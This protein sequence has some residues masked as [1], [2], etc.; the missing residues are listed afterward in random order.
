MSK[1]SSP[2]LLYIT[3]ANKS[4]AKRIA[5]TLLEEKLIACANILGPIRSLF[6]WKG[7]TEDTTEFLLLCKTTK[8]NVVAARKIVLALH[9][10]ECPCI[11]SLPIDNGHGPYFDWI[12]E[13]V[14]HK[15]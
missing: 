1:I 15:T 9:S 14:R 12:E 13:S 5:K 8:M 11:L 10:Y 4:E 2:I 3:A 6:C 7:R